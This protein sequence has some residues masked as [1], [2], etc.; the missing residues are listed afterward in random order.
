MHIELAHA[1]TRARHHAR[2][3][4]AQLE[5]RLAR[6]RAELR[7]RIRALAAEHAWIA[8]LASSFPALLVALAFPR[9]RV[10]V[11]EAMLLVTTGA[12]LATIAE[13]VGVPLWLRNFS[14]EAFD[15]ALPKL[16]DSAAFRRRIANHPPAAWSHA[17]RWLESVA[18][19]ADVADEEIALWFAR[20]NPAK[21]KRRRRGYQPPCKRRLVALWAWHSRHGA[22]K[23]DAWQ[24]DMNWKN[25]LNAAYAWSDSL[26]LALFL[27]ETPVAD[28]WLEDGAVDGYDFIGLH[29]A[30]AV[31][32][33][34]AAMKHCA[35]TYGA[36]LAGNEY[37]LWSIRRDGARVATMS[38]SADRLV[39]PTIREIS[40]LANAKVPVDVFIAARRWLHAQDR[41]DIDAKRFQYRSPRFDA[42][43]W[44]A[45]WRP[46]WLAKRRIPEWLPLTPPA[47]GFLP[48]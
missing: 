47:D 26:E 42:A 28:A 18:L 6:F 36:S 3:R 16:P 2:V 29:T 11:R 30:E 35:H 7:P 14:P 46:Y 4:E 10:D 41:P 40:G 17:P 39:L 21:P 25:A 19:A 8:D 15:R 20:E 32:A 43:A 22:V 1:P 48:I 45:Q 5:T 24:W 44:R 34:A 13:H 38:V 9:P 23:G 12:P 31:R 37:R 27:G 33:E